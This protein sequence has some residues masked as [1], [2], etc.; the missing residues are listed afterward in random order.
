MEILLQK[1]ISYATKE[2]SIF[3]YKKVLRYQL[4]I[5]PNI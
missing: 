2:I 4:L 1:D 3:I 5:I